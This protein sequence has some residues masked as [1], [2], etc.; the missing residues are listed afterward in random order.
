MQA[1]KIGLFGYGCVGQGLYETINNSKNFEGEIKKICIKNPN[2][3]RSLSA[4]LFTTDKS[5]ILN[6]ESI[7]VIVELIDDAEAAFDIVTTAL[8]NGKSVVTANKKMVAENLEYLVK[9]QEETGRA[10]LYEGAVCASIPIIRT[11]EEYFGHEP[12]NE[13]KGIFNGSTN[14]ILTQIFS[15]NTNYKAALA[16]AQKLGFA[17]SDPTLDVK[18]YDAKFKLSILLT[19][20]FGINV[21]PAQIINLGIDHLK[22]A[23]LEYAREN[24]LEVKLIARAKRIGDKVYGFVAPQF[25]KADNRLQEVRNE[26]NAVSLTGEFCDEQLFI[27]KGAGSLPTGAAVLSDISALSYD[28]KYEYKKHINQATLKFSSD[29]LVQV[30]ASFDNPDTIDLNDFESIHEKYFSFDHSYVIGN[31]CINKLKDEKWLN[32]KNLNIVLCENGVEDTL[33]KLCVEDLKA[34]VS[35]LKK[36][37]DLLV[38]ISR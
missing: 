14:Y 38:K 10:V 36:G 18:G 25:T 21:P 28:Y 1:I 6:D 31:V 3:A 34:E 35:E 23:D 16:D 20:A 8:K 7:D 13:I 26:F 33:G 27:G 5:E 29:S 32:N 11:L 15:K 4:D 19:H 30:Y 12:I 22:P 17:E 2:K 9:L 37:H 24:E